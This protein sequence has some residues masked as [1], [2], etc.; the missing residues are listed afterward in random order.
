[1]ITINVA[2]YMDLNTSIL[3]KYELK[4]ELVFILCG[5]SIL[6]MRLI[7]IKPYVLYVSTVHHELHKKCIM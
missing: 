3:L 7:Y 5:S 6:V 1:M 4:Y 2:L